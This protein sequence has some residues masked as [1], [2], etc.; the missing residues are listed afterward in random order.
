MDWLTDAS[1]GADISEILEIFTAG[2]L[3]G[4]C[5]IP[6]FVVLFIIAFVKGIIKWRKKR[7]KVSSNSEN[8]TSQ[9]KN[10]DKIG[11]VQLGKAPVKRNKKHAG[12]GMTGAQL[13]A[14]LSYDTVDS[15]LLDNIVE[16][17][18]SMDLNMEFDSKG[19]SINRRRR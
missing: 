12:L 7:K 10:E 14:E 1:G 13:H 17:N 4:F 18:H 5:L 19:K 16:P 9:A 15:S 3:L 11:V 6:T 2:S 8:K